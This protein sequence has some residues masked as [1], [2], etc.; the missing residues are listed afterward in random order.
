MGLISMVIFGLL[1]QMAGAAYRLHGWK[2]VS[3]SPVVIMFFVNDRFINLNPYPF[4]IWVMFF[5]L[6]A[7]PLGPFEFRSLLLRNA[8]SRRT[9]RMAN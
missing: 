3:L 8:G 9:P 1:L 4:L 7:P 5:A 6:S 2:I